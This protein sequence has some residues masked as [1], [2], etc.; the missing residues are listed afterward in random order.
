MTKAERLEKMEVNPIYKRIVEICEEA[1]YGVDRA[2]ITSYGEPKIGIYPKDSS[3]QSYYPSIYPDMEYDWK[4]HKANFLGWRIQT[5]SY[6]S[7][8]LKEYEKMM[9]IQ[10]GAMRMVRKLEG[11]AISKL[12]RLPDKFDDD[13]KA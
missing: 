6:G 11:L 1:G 10:I 3:F 12:E 8:P 5:T 9:D 7:L 4:N 2:Y 13:D